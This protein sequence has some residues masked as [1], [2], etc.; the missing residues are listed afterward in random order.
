MCS[1]PAAN[2]SVCSPHHLAA[3]HGRKPDRARR[4]RARLTVTPTLH[5]LGQGN[6][7]PSRDRATYG[8]SGAGGRIDLLP[9]MHFQDFG[10]ILFGRQGSGQTPRDRQ[11]QIRARGEISRLH[12]DDPFGGVVYGRLGR[13]IETCCTQYPGASGGRKSGGMA[14]HRIGVGEIDHR[15]A[16]SRQLLCACCLAARS[17]GRIHC[18]GDEAAHAARKAGHSNAHVQS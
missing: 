15:V 16:R 6:T 9:V 18:L 17:R 3:A 2:S 4:A 14:N 13:R 12:H 8:Q 10:V 5:H 1:V 11:N 7:T